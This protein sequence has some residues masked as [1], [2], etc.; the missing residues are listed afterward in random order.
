MNLQLF[1][2]RGGSS[3]MG[4]GS[5]SRIANFTATANDIGSMSREERIQYL[6]DAP[7]GTK[8]SGLVSIRSGMEQVV[9]KH[10]AYSRVYGGVGAG[11]AIL[12]TYWTIGGSKDNYISSTIK[13][14]ADGKSRYYKLKRK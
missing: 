11:S 14:A 10:E 9:E 1:G 3:G 8:I 13:D 7:V 2:G 4:G 5:A 12:E 6:N